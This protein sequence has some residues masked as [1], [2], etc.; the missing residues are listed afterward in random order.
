M[1]QIT[2][3]KI[4]IRTTGLKTLSLT[5]LKVGT[6]YAIVAQGEKG[7]GL[8]S[9]KMPADQAACPVFTIT[10]I[11]D[12]T[13]I[14]NVD[15]DYGV[16]T[17]IPKGFI[18]GGF[19]S[20][21]VDNPANGIVPRWRVEEDVHPTYGQP[22]PGDLLVALWY[23]NDTI[24]YADY[25]ASWLEV[26]TDERT[27]WVKRDPIKTARNGSGDPI[28]LTN[29]TKFLIK[30]T[31]YQSQNVYF[32][33][34]VE[35]MSGPT[36]PYSTIGMIHAINSGSYYPRAPH[37]VGA[38]GGFTDTRN[39]LNMVVE[40][41]LD[42]RLDT[43]M[44]DV[45]DDA[46]P[47]T[48]LGTIR[49]PVTVSTAGKQYV[50]ITNLSIVD[51]YRISATGAAGSYTTAPS[52]FYISKTA[53]A[54]SA[55]DIDPAKVVITEVAE[56]AAD[57]TL[58]SHF[59]VDVS[60]AVTALEPQ[61]IVY[62]QP[63]PTISPS[64]TFV[65]YVKLGQT[66]TALATANVTKDQSYD[67]YVSA[68]SADGRESDYNSALVFTQVAHQY[69]SVVYTPQATPTVTLLGTGELSI[70]GTYTRPSSSAPKP[71]SANLYS[72]PTGISS[73]DLVVAAP[74][75]VGGVTGYDYKILVSGG[76]PPASYDVDGSYYLT[77][78]FK[79]DN[80]DLYP[81]SGRT[82]I[83][84]T[85]SAAGT[86]AITAVQLGAETAGITFT[87]TAST[88]AVTSTTA[89]TP[90]GGGNGT[91]IAYNPGASGCMFQIS[92][93]P[94]GGGISQIAPMS[95]G[96][97]GST[98][99]AV[100]PTMTATGSKYLQ[101]KVTSLFGDSAYSATYAVVF[102]AAVVDTFVP[103]MSACAPDFTT[104]SDG[105][106]TLAWSPASFGASGL[107]SYIVKRS[108][109][110]TNSYTNGVVILTITDSTTNGV[111][112]YVWQDEIPFGKVNVDSYY[113]FLNAVSG[114]GV[115]AAAPI[116]IPDSTNGANFVAASTDVAAPA[117]V[118]SL[119]VK[120]VVGAAT[121]SWV[122]GKELDLW[123]YDIE[124]ADNLTNWATLDSTDASTYVHHAAAYN[125]TAAYVAAHY[126]YRVR[127]RDTGNHTSAWLESTSIDTSNYVPLSGA[128]P[129]VPATVT[130]AL[131][132]D[133]NIT[134]TITPPT[135]N[136]PPAATY[137]IVRKKS[138]DAGSTS[139]IDSEKLV[140]AT[141][142]TV[143]FTDA[144]LD[145]TK[146]YQYQVYTLTAAGM[147]SAAHTDSTGWLQPKDTTAP[148][149]AAGKLTGASQIGSKL[150]TVD[151]PIEALVTIEIWRHTASVALGS[152]ST[153]ATLI[154][155]QRTPHDL[156]SGTFYVKCTDLEPDP[157]VSVSHYYYARAIDASGNASA[158]I[159]CVPNPLASTASSSGGNPELASS[160]NKIRRGSC[161][162]MY[163]GTAYSYS[164]PNYTAVPSYTS[165]LAANWIVGSSPQTTNNY[166]NYTVVLTGA[167][168]GVGSLARITAKVSSTSNRVGLGPDTSLSGS[169]QSDAYLEAGQDYI[170]SIYV[171]KSGTYSASVINIYFP[172]VSGITATAYPTSPDTV[173]GVATTT[174]WVRYAVKLNAASGYA[175]PLSF[176]YGFPSTSTTYTSCLDVSG[177]MLQR[178]STLTPYVDHTIDDIQGSSVPMID[179]D[180]I[181][182]MVA[183]GALSTKKLVV[184]NFDNLVPNPNSE[185][186]YLA[187]TPEGVGLVTNF[188]YES[189]TRSRAIAAST[190]ATMYVTEPLYTT[191]DALYYFEAQVYP[192]TSM[193]TSG[194]LTLYSDGT[195]LP[196]YRAGYPVIEAFDTAGTVLQRF[197][198]DNP[199]AAA[200]GWHK[201]AVSMTTATPLP[202]GT[203]YVRFGLT[204]RN[205]AASNPYNYDN[206]YARR[207]NDGALVVDGSLSANDMTTGTLN[208]SVVNVTNLNA[209]NISTGYLDAARIN[210]GSLNADKITAGTIAFD[211]L[212]NASWSMGTSGDIRS[213]T[214]TA[215]TSTGSTFSSFAAGTGVRINSAVYYPIFMDG[216][217]L[218]NYSGA[219]GGDVVPVQAEFGANVIVGGAKLGDAMMSSLN[220]FEMG[221]YSDGSSWRGFYRGMNSPSTNGGSPNISCLSIQ[222]NFE[223]VANGGRIFI[224][225]F[226]QPTA[227]TD[228][229][230][231][232]R[233]VK[234]EFWEATGA[235]A[236]GTKRLTYYA[237]INDRLFAHSTDSNAANASSAS[238]YV[239]YLGNIGALSGNSPRWFILAT[240]Y[241]AYGPS[242]SNWFSS[243]ATVN[244]NWTNNGTS[245][246]VYGGTTGDSG[247]GTGGR[248]VTPNTPILLA[249]GMYKLAGD[250]VVG[251]LLHT[252]HETTL[253]WGNYAVEAVEQG[254]NSCMHLTFSGDV[255]L[256]T[257][258]NHRMYTEDGWTEAQHMAIGTKLLPS[259]KTLLSAVQVGTQP[260][261]KMTVEEAHTFMSEGG[262]L[263]H[264]IKQILL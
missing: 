210:A 240:L 69:T 127:A 172:T 35:S 77:I 229:L 177:E 112:K 217:A 239:E 90:G 116:Q 135:T 144:G 169:A 178:G 138:A 64:P 125:Q 119:V 78:R 183:D 117:A 235:G 55:P 8:T 41:N 109:S 1:T 98:W 173:T 249:S 15:T 10:D 81:D 148:T 236:T 167:P 254:T 33:G 154:S 201:L 190:T 6:L 223:D 57:G 44:M 253:E 51:N 31:E 248:C 48:V 49:T 54:L 150:L 95:F 71:V 181:V 222:T 233:H 258:V 241:N 24:D 131:L 214:Y 207:K 101:A 186:G 203:S 87:C 27:T 61:A 264:N 115:Q 3:L 25:K 9:M 107:G 70:T 243:P 255:G 238:F 188:G 72:T 205:P 151:C 196:Y 23:P 80:G 36:S 259:G 220:L 191:P 252:Q 66:S 52:L 147:S 14:T 120:A 121:L 108:T 143:L 140:P 164:S 32:R 18:V 204:H 136:V 91:Q 40:V 170:F 110:P 124:F 182:N 195:S 152:V 176:V 134:V 216:G 17:E 65:D 153:T 212:Q 30:A 62:I 50:R 42:P 114:A 106:I 180:T 231:A 130:A 93:N 128:A 175:G 171:K 137:R 208:A 123:A 45:V 4:P 132:T 63:T 226:L 179:N 2:P 20:M 7:D 242:A 86:P 261:T 193:G 245:S 47:N 158:F 84:F 59:L 244:T 19:N 256:T 46:N 234:L 163:A 89:Y 211:R 74:V 111:G 67:I 192:G 113:Y 218:K 79:M 215:A 165:Y 105:S 156:T 56:T 202:P 139:A 161:R 187:S 145:T 185:R 250:I 12:P 43:F 68:L 162:N 60:A 206:M 227:L 58:V 221:P 213:N 22:I 88:F 168:V 174:S 53:L 157:S 184:A 26:S 76:F 133:S 104:N 189:T 246:P 96:V 103:D 16:T 224:N 122:P 129:N 262:I 29:P 142:A 155:S 257:S 247:G 260:V 230:E 92:T 126:R 237:P 28:Y 83:K 82:V 166:L 99:S 34:K 73:G 251:D 5:G 118:T 225:L 198:P 146:T 159:A 97:S 21:Q 200:G 100:I 263:N 228:N 199:I 75:S 13:L 219:T 209:A 197:T 160:V 141:A 37:I 11:T 38:T 39:N 94:G 149:L 194:T 85:P 102:P 232:M